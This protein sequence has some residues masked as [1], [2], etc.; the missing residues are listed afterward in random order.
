VNEARSTVHA[1]DMAKGF[2]VPIVHVNADDPEACLAA[3]RLALMYR[4]KFSN[5][6]VIDLVGYRRHGHN[7]G[8]EPRYTQPV[9]Y[10]RI[11]ALATRILICWS[12]RG[13]SRRPRPTPW[14]TTSTASWR[15]S[16]R[17]SRKS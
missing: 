11:D 7:E 15:R 2:D 16:S 13:S 8:D 5:D 12:G 3:V 17:S 10:Q 6:C 9:M 14:P 1:S 4:Q